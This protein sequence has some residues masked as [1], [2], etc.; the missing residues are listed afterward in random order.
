MDS[1][2]FFG[3]LLSIQ[4]LLKPSALFGLMFEIS[5]LTSRGMN[6]RILFLFRLVLDIASYHCLNI[7]A[8][9]RTHTSVLFCSLRAQVLTWPYVL[10][11]VLREISRIKWKKYLRYGIWTR[12]SRTGLRTFNSEP[13]RTDHNKSVCQTRNFY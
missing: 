9:C 6:C 7:L 13:P 4:V 11:P 2:V 10:W 1:T 8:R 5:L 3:N 12:D